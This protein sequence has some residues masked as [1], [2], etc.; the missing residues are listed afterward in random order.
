[1]LDCLTRK[2][3]TTMRSTPLRFG[4]RPLP[5]R[6][7]AAAVSAVLAAAVVGAGPLP[8]GK[9]EEVGL[10]SQRLRRVGELMERYIG[11]GDISGGVTLITRRGRVA[12]FEAHGLMDIESKTKM[13]KDAIFRI[14]SMTKPVT[15]VAIL[16]LVEEGKVRLTDPVHRFVPELKDMKVAVPRAARSG[17]EAGRSADPSF[18]LVPAS[19]PI[20]VKDL[21]THTAGLVTNGPGAREAARLAPRDPS[22]RLATHIPKLGAVPLD[23]QPGTE[24]RYS[25]LEGLDTLARIVEVAS[26]LNF[27]Q[28][29]QQR[30][31]E[32]LGMRDTGF[33]APPEKSDKNGRVASLYRKTVKGLEAIGNPAWLSA[34]LLSGGAGLWS[35]AEDYAQFAQ[36]L[37]NGGELNGKRILGPRTVALMASNHVGQKYSG[38]RGGTPGMGFGLTVE[39][40]TDSVAGDQARSTGSFGW[41][42]AFGSHFWVDLKEQLA[43]V[44]M[45]Q[46]LSIPLHRD[47]ESAV[48]QAIVD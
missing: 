30:I 43:G 36:M 33:G 38:I 10:S 37:A 41:F 14:A 40:V 29:L 21:M 34:S 31:F 16:M 27:D 39:V 20:T 46:T 44:L 22:G 45:V 48:M 35:T 24:W 25:G 15:G 13:R 5:V 1:M 7:A 11:A 47:F 23:F 42:G 6:F 4:Q 26:G 3:D 8:T 19:R 17:A 18:D 32:P 2:D 12:H 28:F 9:A